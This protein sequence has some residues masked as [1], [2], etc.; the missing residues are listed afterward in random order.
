MRRRFDDD[1]FE[2]D[3]LILLGGAY[4]GLTDAG[5]LLVAFDEVTDGDEDSWV[6]VFRALAERLEAQAQASATKRRTQSARSA[7][8]RASSYF[9]TAAAHAVG[10]QG[11]DVATGLWER[12]R[13]AWDRA[14]AAF[15]PPVEH[16]SV[17]YTDDASGTSVPLEGYFFSPTDSASVGER[18]PTVILTNGSDGPVCDMWSAGAAAAVERGWNAMTYDGPG[19]GASLYRHGLHFRGDWEAVLTPVVDHLLSRPDVDS[20]RLAVVGVSQAGYW[21]PRALAFE[22][23]LAAGVA[24]PGVTR[25]GDSWLSHL[26][27]SMVGILDSGDRADFDA[28][29][30]IGLEDSPQALAQLR[31]RMDPYG[32]D[33]FFDAYQAARAMRLDAATAAAIT[34]PVLITSPDHEQFWPGQSEELHQ[35]VRGS[36]LIRFTEAEGASWHC[37]PAG[38]AIRDERVMDWLADVFDGVG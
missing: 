14:V 23:R 26:P 10:S 15:D 21:V 32:T 12:H 5:E 7:D 3:R 29:M 27:E 37:E 8:L 24:D 20:E 33:S 28:F 25:V 6:R 31:W 18:R 30:E 36:T 9:A 11:H 35:L 19:Q 17:A 22:H 4:R 13:G 16:L 1:G 38:R 34:T 2:F